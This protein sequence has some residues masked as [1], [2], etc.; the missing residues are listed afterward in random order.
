MSAPSSS[1]AAPSALHSGF[2]TRA[3]LFWLR[4]LPPAVCE[5][6]ARPVA[7][8][9]YL[10]ATEQ[11][12][13]V[14]K[15]MLA[16]RPEQGPLLAWLAGWRVFLNFGLTYMDRLWHLYHGKP[17]EWV[18]HGEAHLQALQAD[19]GGALIFTIHSGNYDIGSTLFAERLGRPLHM[20]RIAEQE[21]TLQAMRKAELGR[22]HPMLHV[23]YNK[24][25]AHLGLLLCNLLRSNQVVAVQGDRVLLD[26]ASLTI[27][28]QHT[29]YV[30][31]RGPFMLAEMTRV[32]CY[33]IFL[34]RVGRLRY[35]VEIFPALNARGEL[36][37]EQQLSRRWLAVLH[38]YLV[39]YAEQW[40]VF[41]QLLTEV[42]T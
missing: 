13:A 32:P 2:L 20:V 23:H 22:I 31:P 10:L 39:K 15:N 7:S 40:F 36:L 3:L 1:A 19:P 9:I 28:H 30:L 33:P 21:E 34:R 42:R 35:A 25:D 6:L 14:C 17:V 41:E 37:Q 29:G 12:R 4:A 18:P 5:L 27:S 26:V 24:P 8:I 11:R 38:P 16:L